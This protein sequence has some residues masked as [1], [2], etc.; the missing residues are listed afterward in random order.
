MWVT[1]NATAEMAKRY[2]R[3]VIGSRIRDWRWSAFSS[4]V[5]AAVGD[6]GRADEQA[7]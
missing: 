2:A 7:R 5:A 3:S 1:V 6:E 4:T